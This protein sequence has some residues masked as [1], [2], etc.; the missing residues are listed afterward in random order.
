MNTSQLKDRLIQAR[1]ESGI[2]LPSH[3]AM[4]AGITPSAL[5]QLEAGKTKSL[6]AE[7]AQ[8]LAKVYKK[9]NVSW[10]VNAS[11][12]KYSEYLTIRDSN[13][14]YRV[15]TPPA[16]YC[17]FGLMEGSASGGYG[18]VNEDFPEVL[19]SIEIAEWKVRQQLGFVPSDDRV[20]ILT[21]RGNSNYPKIKDGDVVMVDTSQRTYSGDDF[22][23]IN[24]HG[25][26]L[27]KRL[28]IMGDGLHIRSTNP[29]YESEVIPAKHIA[30]IMIG[31]RILGFAQFR[32]SEEI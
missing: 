4:Q 25:F 24:I 31:G 1:I 22:Y 20:Q 8:N 14:E 7:R 17:R 5:Y 2:D 26:T 21:V 15:F 32:R 27:I 16:G 12:P 11:G 13:Q 10:L 19:Q 29:E 30:D 28:Q 6:K 23:L 3:A 9:F 18:S